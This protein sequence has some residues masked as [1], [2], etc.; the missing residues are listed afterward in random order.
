MD[1]VRFFKSEFFKALANPLRI[2]ILDVLRNGEC[3]VNEM[4]ASL[5]VEQASLSQQLSVL[6]SKRLVKFRKEGNYVYYSIADP[7]IFSLL[8]VA[9]K[10]FQNHL[11]DLQDVLGGISTYS[12]NESQ[13]GT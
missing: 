3:G 2:A 4:A 7:T 13:E 6:R 1:Q 5:N 12:A 10:I 8:D 11:V 9:A